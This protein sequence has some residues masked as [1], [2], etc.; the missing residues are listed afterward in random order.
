M[1]D[2]KISQDYTKVYVHIVTW[3]K[4]QRKGAMAGIEPSTCKKYNKD[5][6]LC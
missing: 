6:P 1:L 3:Q 4:M 2:I 5:K